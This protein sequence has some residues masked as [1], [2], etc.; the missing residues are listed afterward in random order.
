[1]SVRKQT[2][3]GYAADCDVNV[4]YGVRRRHLRGVTPIK[5]TAPT[6]AIAPAGEQ[7]ESPFAAMQANR[8]RNN[9][10]FDALCKEAR[11]LPPILQ[12]FIDRARELNQQ[13]GEPMIESRVINTAKSIFRYVETGELRTGEHGAWFKKPPGRF[14]CA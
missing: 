9:A 5:S 11:G 12:A 14:A 6:S 10:L 4:C 8:G 7:K 3:V 13:F 2:S 1:M